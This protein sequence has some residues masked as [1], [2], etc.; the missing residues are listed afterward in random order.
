MSAN[1]CLVILRP[2]ARRWEVWMQDADTN[3]FLGRPV[4]C[5]SLEKA[6]KAANKIMEE[7]IVEYGI[8]HIDT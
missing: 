4:K 5:N 1:N 2:T 3:A 8:V 7:E 6:V